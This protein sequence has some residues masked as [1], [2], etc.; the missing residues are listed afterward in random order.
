MVTRLFVV[1][2]V[3]LAATVPAVV[4]AAEAV[5]I[6]SL[7][8]IGDPNES[9]NAFGP[10][11]ATI[12]IPPHPAWA[13]PLA[14]SFWVS[15]ASDSGQ[16]GDPGAPGYF[17]PANGTVIRFVDSFVLE[18]GP[19][20]VG[21]LTVMADDSTAV[22]LNGNL[23]MSEASSVGNTYTTCSDFPIGCLEITRAT[24]D[25]SPFLQ[26]GL[27]TLWFDVA[28]RNGASYGLDYAGEA[29]AV[30]EPGTMLLLG[31][32]LIGVGAALR[33]RVSRKK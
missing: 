9:N 24:I 30:P 32:G 14:G 21:S 8:S 4:P 22:Y 6:S 11:T 26:A 33:R 5:L 2:L 17:S 16:T 27:N 7:G 25:L 23:L 29:A 18:A 15:F 3:A 1:M 28:Q 31:S 12:V 20:Y 10:A 13:P 19:G